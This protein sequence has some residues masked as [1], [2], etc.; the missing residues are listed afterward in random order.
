MLMGSLL[1]GTFFFLFLSLFFFIHIL[2]FEFFCLFVDIMFLLCNV[3]SFVRVLGFVL[4]CFVVY[5]L[6]GSGVLI[7]I[8]CP[9][10][11]RAKMFTS[12]ILYMPK[13]TC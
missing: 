2:G 9:C 7:C 12:Y 5:E 8:D 11:N 3:C 4:Q 10:I 13:N 6:D 1:R